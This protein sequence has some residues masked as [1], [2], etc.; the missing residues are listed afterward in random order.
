MFTRT[1]VPR[2]FDLGGGGK[3]EKS[4]DISLVTFFGDVTTIAS[5][6]LHHN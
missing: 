3:M 4:C 5:L 2:K 6:T 1:G